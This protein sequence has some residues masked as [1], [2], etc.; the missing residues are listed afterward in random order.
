MRKSTWSLF[1]LIV[2][3]S[4]LL[5]FLAWTPGLAREQVDIEILSMKFGGAGYVKSFVMADLINKK[6][7]WLRATAVETGGT[8]DNIKILSK[9]RD[10]V[11]KRV[12]NGSL[13]T[14]YDARNAISPFQEK[15][16]GDIRWLSRDVTFLP[17]FAATDPNIR[18]GQDLKGKRLGLPRAGSGGVVLPEHLLKN[19][20]NIY[21]DVKIEYLGWGGSPQALVDGKVDA[22]WLSGTLFKGRLVPVPAV[23]KI[24]ASGVKLHSIPASPADLRAIREKTG[25]PAYGMTFAPGM[26]FANQMEEVHIGILANGFFAD[27]ELPEDIAYEFVRIFYENYEEFGKHHASLKG[28]SPELIS[29]AGAAEECHPG[30]AKFYKEKGLKIGF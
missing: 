19:A 3:A 16:N 18:T 11:T 28:I 8:V 6:S 27:A 9:E 1:V 10:K 22:A 29:Q 25:F 4:L 24:V 20:W 5:V 30:A 17:H 7:S 23:E 26:L 14:L 13:S 21:D 12:G 15:Y 2:V